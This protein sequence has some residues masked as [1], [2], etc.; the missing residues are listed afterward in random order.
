MEKF[1]SYFQE[2][3]RK[4]VNFSTNMSAKPDVLKFHKNSFIDHNLAQQNQVV[5]SL[6][7]HVISILLI[8]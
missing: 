7:N 5:C 4:F 3:T 1:V 2:W 6:F 8:T